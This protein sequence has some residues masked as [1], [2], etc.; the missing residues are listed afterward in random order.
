[1]STAAVECDSQELG[2]LEPTYTAVYVE[3]LQGLQDPC[4]ESVDGTGRESERGRSE[5]WPKS[6][7]KS[8]DKEFTPQASKSK[9]KRIKFSRPIIPSSAQHAS[10]KFA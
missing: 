8:S 7:L 10:Q 9:K 3:S 4:N 5:K 6:V 1:M 2:V